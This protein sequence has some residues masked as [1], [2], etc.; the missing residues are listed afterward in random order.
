VE[1]ETDLDSQ[2]AQCREVIRLRP[3]FAG[4]YQGLGVIHKWRGQIVEAIPLFRKAASLDPDFSEAYRDL[5]GALAT[6]GQTRE[7]LAVLENYRSRHPEDRVAAE[8]ER[9][10]RVDADSQAMAPQ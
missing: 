10:I 4:G 8:L 2:Q 6:A 9:A 7:A 5:A 3:A 1:D